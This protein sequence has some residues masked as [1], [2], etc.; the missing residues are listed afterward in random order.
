MPG[1]TNRESRLKARQA[2]TTL[3]ARVDGEIAVLE[4]ALQE[5]REPPL[6]ETV[7]KA[8]DLVAQLLRGYIESC[9]KPSPVGERDV[10]VLFKVF[11][12]GDPSLNA[13]RDSIRELVY[14][15]HCIDASRPDALPARP[16]RMAVRTLR[17]IYLY[18][19]TRCL[20]ED[21][22]LAERW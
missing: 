19:R 11:V 13:V 12:K 8:L 5:G 9:D 14:Y 2:L 10:L 21:R 3:F 22:I 15:R 16:A 20:K 6:Q 7:R 4:S 18:L 1:T 17:H